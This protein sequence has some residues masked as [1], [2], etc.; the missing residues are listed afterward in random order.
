MSARAALTAA[1]A[2]V[3]VAA[4]LA[5][6]WLTD[7]DPHRWDAGERA[8]LRSLSLAALPPLPP[9]PGN[10]VADDPAAAALGGRLFFDVRMSSNGAVSCA[11]CHQPALGFSD[12]LPRGR[13]VGTSARHTPSLLG[14]AF[15]PWRYWDGRKDSLWSQ[16]LSPLEDPAEHGTDRHAIAAF[17]AG[18]GHYRGAY[19]AV[20]GP[21][22]VEPDAAARTRV[23]VNAGKAMAA[24]QRRIEPPRT[25]FDE[26]VDAVLAG[27]TAAARALLTD[28][29]ARGLRLFIGKAECLQCHN[30]PLFSNHE[31]HNTGVLAA[32]GE[33]PDRGRIDGL[34]ALDS[35]PFGCLGGWVDPPRPDCDE[36]RFA[37]RGPEL[38]GAFRTPT[39]RNVAQTAPYMHRGQIATLADVIDHYDRAPPAMIGHNEA[40][41]LGLSPWE[42]QQLEAFLHTLDGRPRV[43]GIER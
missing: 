28:G 42:R 35:D 6:A 5:G 40:K 16:A 27:D 38:I 17:I 34:R 30:G 41:P 23:F 10:A 14:A 31:F 21:L 22:P 8:L 15:S 7:E 9:D 11:T 4:V 24:F 26:Y 37:R 1:A 13:G 43:P 39:L 25:R 3:I 32:P 2:V 19:E 29:E 18:D 20:F 33:L 12:G 36:V